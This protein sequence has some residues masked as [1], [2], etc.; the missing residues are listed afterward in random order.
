MILLSKADPGRKFYNYAILGDDIV[1]ADSQIAKAYQLLLEEIGVTISLP[2]SLISHKGC[3]EFAKRFRVRDGRI[4]VS[5]ISM[6]ALLV[7]HHPYGLMS[8][9]QKK[10][11][12]SIDC[13]HRVGGVGFNTLARWPSSTNEDNFGV[14]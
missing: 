2:K 5:P 1:I 13:R 7:A 14:V 9:Y 4:D 8:I 12:N 11:R 3:C 6:R 10:N